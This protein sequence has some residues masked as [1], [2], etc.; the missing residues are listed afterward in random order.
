MK[1]FFR[2]QT[3]LLVKMESGPSQ[4]ERNTTI[5]VSEHFVRDWSRDKYFYA[6]ASSLAGELCETLLASNGIRA[7]VTH[8]VKQRKRLEEKLRDRVNRAGKIYR[9]PDDIRN[10]VVDLAGVRIAI[11]FPSDGE[12]IR[13]IIDDA[14]SDIVY[15]SFPY[16]K[17]GENT[18]RQTIQ[19]IQDHGF[20]QRFGGYFASHYRV[21]MRIENLS[22]AQLREDFKNLNPVIEIQVA[23]VL[24]HAW[25][26]V[27]HDLVYKTLTDGAASRA[28]L[29][30]LDAI[31]GLA[32]TGEILL[33]EL[34]TAIDNRVSYQKQTFSDQF[35]LR[36]FLRTQ[37]KIQSDAWGHLDILYC[38]LRVIGIDSPAT[39]APY[40]ERWTFD[41][42]GTQSISDSLL[43]LILEVKE[44]T[45][46]GGSLFSLRRNMEDLHKEEMKVSNTS[47][48]KQYFSVSN[49]KGMEL[50]LQCNILQ[51]AVKIVDLFRFP[52]KSLLILEF[53]SQ[54]FVLFHQLYNQ[55]PGFNINYTIE[56]TSN[57]SIPMDQVIAIDCLWTWFESNSVSIFR[58]SLRLARIRVNGLVEQLLKLY[59]SQEFQRQPAVEE[60]DPL[61]EGR[62]LSAPTKSS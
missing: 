31:N 5:Q 27:D 47:D 4:E 53:P 51:D 44:E 61:R 46:V 56:N 17:D 23:S 8:R 19:A 25:A 43:Q 39:I 10:D 41:P 49:D 1:V 50:L 32:H 3:L 52:K 36:S 2:V 21:K 48:G 60:P 18:S 24:M 59:T 37:K 9:S 42:T 29:R 58:T 62:W 11:Y 12:K 16:Q 35:E 22:S 30:L 55:I 40:L 13:K 34:Q 45:S 57:W 20:K 28:E 54:E 6:Q 7:I 33:Q 15:R 38:T 14:F 26:E